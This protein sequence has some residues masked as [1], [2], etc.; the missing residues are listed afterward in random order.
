[1]KDSLANNALDR[2][3]EIDEFTGDSLIFSQFTHAVLLKRQYKFSEAAKQFM[4]IYRVKNKLSL[5]AGMLA[6]GLYNKLEKPVDAISLLEDIIKSYPNDE[7]T[8]M[9]YFMLASGFKKAKEFDKALVLYE[10]I[11]IRFPTSFYN[12][13]ARENAREINSFLQEKP[14]P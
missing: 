6:V 12:E 1:M 11:L 7:E 2:I 5:K 14:N 8:D 9:A 10:E 3:F 13:Q 4:E